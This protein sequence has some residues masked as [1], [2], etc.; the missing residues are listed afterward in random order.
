V[1]HIFLTDHPDSMAHHPFE[2]LGLG[3]RD[4]DG[5]RVLICQN[6]RET[7][8]HIGFEAD[9][10][11]IG[12]K[13]H[14]DIPIGDALERAYREKDLGLVHALRDKDALVLVPHTEDKDTEW[15]RQLGV[16]G[17]EIINLHA[18]V[19]PKIRG[20]HLGMQ[21][22]DPIPNLLGL[23]FD[24]YGRHSPDFFQLYFLNRPAVPLSKW[25]ALL[26]QGMKVFG[27]GGT[28]SHENALPFKASD[29][30]RLDS[31]RRMMRVLSHYVE[32]GPVKEQLRRGRFWIVMEGL[33]MPER[34]D[35]TY[36]AFR[37]GS[38]AP[39][40]PGVWLHMK[41][42]RPGFQVRLSLFKDGQR[43]Q[44]FENDELWFEPSRGIYRV[45]VEIQPLHLKK[46]APH[47]MEA[48]RA[49]YPWM[50][51]QPIWIE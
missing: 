45:E 11:P 27:Y 4:E 43:V 34:L 50:Y 1:D 44:V 14:L 7:K 42:P 13:G 30:E 15:I 5:A 23:A 12:L 10:M 17:I 51:S 3:E 18:L 25:D 40:Q 39:F 29:G 46:F 47:D 16:D 37:P 28:D 9:L 48:L 36:G 33:G 41:H 22:L 20:R 49:W 38:Q 32:E 24:P 19:D 26:Q 2:L 31:H 6:G 21:A 35:L 8:F